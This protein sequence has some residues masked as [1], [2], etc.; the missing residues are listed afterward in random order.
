MNLTTPFQRNKLIFL[1]Q[2]YSAL[3]PIV[4]ST[5]GLFKYYGVLSFNC[6]AISNSVSLL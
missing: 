6:H 3:I 4:P 5:K 2:I 1:R